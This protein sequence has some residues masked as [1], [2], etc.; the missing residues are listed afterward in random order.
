MHRID[1]MKRLNSSIGELGKIIKLMME[2]EW[3][4]NSIVEHETEEQ[5]EETSGTTRPPENTTDHMF[6]NAKRAKERN[7]GERNVLPVSI[8]EFARLETSEG[9]GS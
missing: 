8:P 5:K 4:H 7:A 3:R 1:Q 6:N 2:R 9:T